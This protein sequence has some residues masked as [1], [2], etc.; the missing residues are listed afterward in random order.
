MSSTPAK[1]T[2][3]RPE[4]V[5]AQ[6]S[7]F[8]GTIRIATPPRLV[9]V[10]AM[11]LALVLALV[12]FAIL[13][14]ATRKAQVAGVLLPPGGLLQLTS[15]QTASLKS[16][17]VN[18]GQ[19]VKKGQ[20]LAV[21]E[22]G[23]YSDKG[24]T[25]TLLQQNLQARATALQAESRGT[26][27]QAQQREQA[28]R[29]RLRSLQRDIIQA[30]GELE[31][32]QQRVR[33]AQANVARDQGLSVQGFLSA[34]Q[35]QTRQ[36][37]LLEIQTRE[38][39]AQRSLE[40]L[41]REAQS[42]QAEIDTTRLQAHTQQAQIARTQATLAQES[43]E[44]DA[45]HLLHLVAPSPAIVGAV[46]V[47]PG[48]SLQSGQTVLSL[49]PLTHPASGSRPRIAAGSESLPIQEEALPLQAEHFQTQRFDTAPL[50]A[51]LYA[52]SRTAGFVE[53]GQAVWLRL[54]AFPYQ[55]FGMVPGSVAEVSRTPVLPQD[56]PSGMASALMSA[57]QSQEPLYRI[58]VALQRDSF[59]AFGKAQPL[60]A[61]MSLEADVIQDRRAIW[62]WVLEPLLAA[63]A[64]WKIPSNAPSN[65]SPGGD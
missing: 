55:K 60:K 34:A 4:A 12:A 32:T 36:E 47:H 10:A 25:A 37:E 62:E 53:P 13:G 1:P 64:R 6:S 5:A 22:L 15:P 35:L 54:H 28:L 30:Q 26:Q 40:A 14:Q 65:T 24:P 7:Q 17:Q 23:G 2:L 3:F 51:Q 41:S 57:A 42:V 43:T 58:T 18:E 49:I 52:P 39:S 8:L 46:S 29:D 56:L 27:A 20:L 61:G 19:A 48:Q 21:L 38:R 50:Q 45:R 16:I 11:A 63:K 44:L 33:M 9:A 59:Q 31:A